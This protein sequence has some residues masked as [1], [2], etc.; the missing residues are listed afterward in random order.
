[1]QHHQVRRNVGQRILLIIAL[2]MLVPVGLAFGLFPLLKTQPYQSV[3]EIDPAQVDSLRVFF[4]N[5][6]ELDGGED[7]GPYFAAEEDY[8]K[9]LAPLVA[10][11]RVEDYQSARGPWLGELRIRTK[12]GRRA[13]IRLYWQRNP[14]KSTVLD[15]I[16]ATA[17][18][19]LIERANSVPVYSPGAYQLRFQ[20]GDERYEGGNILELIQ[21]AQS[22]ESRGVKAQ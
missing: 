19:L 16:G 18:G 11:P 17:G 13:T 5:R 14:V 20:I 12:V 10:V 22:A 1:M 3:E 2:L 15:A 4:L 9:L 21:A 7:I 8:A 6:T